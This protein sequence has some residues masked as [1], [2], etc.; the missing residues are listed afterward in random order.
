MFLT[1][2][3]LTHFRNYRKL[4]LD[5][6]STVTVLQGANAQGKTNLLEAIYFLATSKPVHAGNEREVV[7]W[8]AS[9]E[10][11]PYARIAAEVQLDGRKTELEI[12]LTPR[13]DGGNF[14]KQIRIN[15]VNRRG[16]DLVG[17]L[18]AVLF[19]PE[20]IRL[21]DGSPS[22]RRRYLDIALCQM[23]RA[24]C[25]ALS[26][27]NK[28]L[29]Q[30]NSLLRLLRE[31]EAPSP[32]ASIE[33]QLGFWDDQLV[34]TG[35]LVILSR[36]RLL[37]ELQEIA[38]ELHGELSRGSETLALQ[39][40]PSFNPGYFDDADFARLESETGAAIVATQP[41]RP[42][43]LDT[44]ADRF[45]A[46]IHARRRREL[47]AATTLYGPHRDDFR[48]LV[49]GRDQRLY[50]SRGQQRS[51]ALATKLAEVRVMTRRT[52]AAPLLLLDDVMSELD[53]QRRGM[54]LRTL[55]GVQQ[56]I[57]TTTDWDDFAPDFLAA[58]RRWQVSAGTIAAAAGAV[59][60]AEATTPQATDGNF[61]DAAAG[62]EAVASAAPGS[63]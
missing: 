32:T 30:R 12:L 43:T 20:D 60:A 4:E 34:S 11:I 46:Q 29:E 25:R 52:G 40:L 58:A 23:E 59:P 7:D 62:S 49:N 36:Y 31:Q 55:D 6:S 57:L 51:A 39:Y 54:L 16:I 45:R 15:G 37:R 19:L 9:D 50:G 22:D 13:D 17:L 56:A 33:A 5:F 42:L 3:S 26:Q 44:V 21:V 63:E 28:V 8:Q 14:K 53:A 1:H 18:R 61:T 48:F 47:D 41:G 35:S 2:L 27:Y 38:T 10:P 24:Y